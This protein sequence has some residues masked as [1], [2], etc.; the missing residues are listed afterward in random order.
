MLKRLILISFCLFSWGISAIS[1]AYARPI[2]DGEGYERILGYLY[3]SRD[4]ISEPLNNTITVCISVS[5][6][7]TQLAVLVGFV[8]YFS[9]A[10]Y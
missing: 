9:F 6:L 4:E 8:F 2:T 7:L 10:V 1:S 3:V 5:L